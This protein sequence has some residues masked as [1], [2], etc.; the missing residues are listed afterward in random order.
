MNIALGTDHVRDAE[1]GEWY[2]YPDHEPGDAHTF[3]LRTAN[4]IDYDLFVDGEYAFSD[5]FKLPSILEA[6]VVWGDGTTGWSTARWSY[7]RVGVSAIGDIDIDGRVDLNDFATFAMCYTN[8]LADPPPGCSDQEFALSDLD[9]DGDTDLA[10]FAIFA[11][12]FTG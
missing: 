9:S 4:L 11:V 8:G 12:N 6:K 7:F 10:D 3:I 2:D 5:V 1:G